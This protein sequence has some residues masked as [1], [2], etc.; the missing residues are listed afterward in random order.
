MTPEALE[1]K[2]LA[3]IETVRACR[4]FRLRRYQRSYAAEK[5]RRSRTTKQ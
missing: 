1:V 3:G 4:E 2:R 5:R